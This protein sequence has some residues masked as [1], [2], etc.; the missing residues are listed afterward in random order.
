MRTEWPTHLCALLAWPCPFCV[1]EDGAGRLLLREG[2]LDC[3]CCPVVLLPLLLQWAAGQLGFS[4]CMC[5]IDCLAFPPLLCRWFSSPKPR[6][7]QKAK[8][9][10][11]GNK[12]N[13]DTLLLTT[14]LYAAC[15]EGHCLGRYPSP[16]HQLAFPAAPVGH[17]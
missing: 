2:G 15:L 3:C 10:R 12:S 5:L 1:C 9:T 17:T 7:F 8:E 11:A 13:Y 4:G 16:R 14:K 6:P